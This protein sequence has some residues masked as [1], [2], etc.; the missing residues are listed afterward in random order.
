MDNRRLL[1]S[2]SISLVILVLFQVIAS[3]V[4]PPPKKAPPHPATQTAQTQPV[5]GQPAP[6]VPAPNGSRPTG[7]R[8]PRSASGALQ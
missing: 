2:I 1:Y 4:L 8:P 3:Y 5:S 6:G 7:G